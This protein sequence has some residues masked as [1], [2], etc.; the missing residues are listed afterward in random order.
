MRACAAAVLACVLAG[1]AAL[2][3]VEELF[4]RHVRVLRPQ[5]Q[6]AQRLIKVAPGQGDSWKEVSDSK[7]GFK[8]MLPAR[9]EVDQ[10]PQGSR[11]LLAALSESQI[12]PRALLRIDHFTPKPEE[13]TVV[14][15]DYLEEYVKQYPEQA[16]LGKLTVTDSGL[17]RKGKKAALAMV[18]G[19]YL[20]GAAPAHRLQWTYLSK[21][22]QLF[23]TFDCGEAE[24]PDYQDLVARI[25]LSLDVESAVR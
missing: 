17:V 8:L 25:L 15:L 21:D 11:V 18:G 7:A 1:G 20:Q 12:R 19:S 23:I 13:P 6:F 14:D 5:G 2:A 4:S 16:G 22:R 9:A 10:S 24:W 3:Q